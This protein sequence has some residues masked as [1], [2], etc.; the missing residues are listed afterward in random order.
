MPMVGRRQRDTRGLGRVAALPGITGPRAAYGLHRT[1]GDEVVWGAI[2]HHHLDH[3]PRA[4]LDG[5]SVR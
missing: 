5:G 1:V 4:H 3:V 2:R